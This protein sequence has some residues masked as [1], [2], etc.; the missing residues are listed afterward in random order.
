M[1]ERFVGR[2]V[3]WHIKCVEQ[4]RLKKGGA[5]IV[6][7]IDGKWDSIYRLDKIPI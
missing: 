6:L 7:G 3:V 5:R 4:L 2:K 1:E